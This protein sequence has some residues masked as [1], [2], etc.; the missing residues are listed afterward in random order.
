M[1][2]GQA[3]VLLGFAKDLI[4]PRLKGTGVKLSLCQPTVIRPSWTIRLDFE[5]HAA[6]DLSEART[7]DGLAACMQKYATE[8]EA[9]ADCMLYSLRTYA[10]G[11]GDAS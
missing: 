10:A 9:L 2:E 8:L 4:G 6:L 3:R 5:Y 11:K 7:A 1:N